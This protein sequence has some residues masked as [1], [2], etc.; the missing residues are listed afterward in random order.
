MSS[1]TL[2][3]L[4]TERLISVWLPLKCKELCSRRRIVLAWTIIALLLYG[5]NTHFLFTADLKQ[6]R[7]DNVSTCGYH[8][9]FIRGP[10]YFFDVF[11]GDFV[12]FVVVL[13]GNCLIVAKIVAS[14]RQRTTQMN[15]VDSNRLKVIC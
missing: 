8:L 14:H 13:V 3:L 15:V 11:V 5:V 9:D 10:L 2:I 4:T 7:S 6:R 12:P 1:W